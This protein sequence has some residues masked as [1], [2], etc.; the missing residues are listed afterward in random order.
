M[1]K[2]AIIT[3]INELRQLADT[4]EKQQLEL[5]EEFGLNYDANRK[6]QINIINYMGL[7]DTWHIEKLK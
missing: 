1:E 7:S 5:I 4:L 6:I 3:S 2:Q